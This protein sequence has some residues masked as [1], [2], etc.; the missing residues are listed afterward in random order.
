[1]TDLNLSKFQQ[2]NATRGTR[3]HQGD[4]SQWSLLEWC[5]AMAGEA[6]EACNVAKKMRRIDLMLPNKEAGLS[7]RD[8][9]GLRNKLANE[10]G[11]TIIYGLLILSNLGLDASEVVEYVFDRKSIEYGFPERA[12]DAA[13][14][15]PISSPA[16]PAE[17]L[18]DGER[19]RWA[20][21]NVDDDEPDL[22]VLFE[23][24]GKDDLPYRWVPVAVRVLSPTEPTTAGT[25]EAPSVTAQTRAWEREGSAATH[26]AIASV[27]PSPLTALARDHGRTAEDRDALETIGR[28]AI[29]VITECRDA[30]AVPKGVRLTEHIKELG[31]YA[32]RWAFVR[33]MLYSAERV[34][35]QVVQERDDRSVIVNAGNQTYSSLNYI[36]AGDDAPSV[37]QMLDEAIDTAM[38][39]P[40]Q[41]PPSS[42]KGPQ[43]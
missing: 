36:D 43:P 5:G 26:P 37:E 16:L 2:T 41:T 6:G 27:P 3:W 8:I 34:E 42:T 21:Q 39:S 31:A 32:R 24:R 19:T 25:G 11:D 23:Q 28:V 13:V 38:A 1:M 4:L 22:T 15:D 40:S 18:R 35:I 29:E 9:V 10:I 12:R 30:L 14:P 33:D 7:T 20:Q 17:T